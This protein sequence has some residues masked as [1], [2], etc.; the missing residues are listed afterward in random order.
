LANIEEFHMAGLMIGELARQV[1]VAPSA[2][3]YY[4]K[5][6]LLPPPPRASKRRQYNPNVLGRIRIILL[7]RDAGF[8]I[9]ETRMFLNGFPASTMPT[10]RWREMAKRK[11]AELD[12]LMA[13]VARMKLIL[14]ASFRCECRELEDC[15]RLVAAK[16]CCRSVSSQTKVAAS[17]GPPQRVRAK[18]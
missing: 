17:K 18:R 14:N 7:A 12:E 6:G 4:E 13:R 9:R 15:E 3:C 16:Y 1:G 8:S 5:A 2:L 10:L 11:I